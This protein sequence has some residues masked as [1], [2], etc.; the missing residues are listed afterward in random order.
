[1]LLISVVL[2]VVACAVRLASAEAVRLTLRST[3]M[4][5][6]ISTQTEI[7]RDHDRRQQGEF[8]RRHAAAVAGEARQKARQPQ[9]HRMHGAQTHW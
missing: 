2:M 3:P 6:E 4:P 8:D 9:R 1:M 7:K 5:S